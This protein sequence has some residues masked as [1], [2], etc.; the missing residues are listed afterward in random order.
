MR[1]VPQLSGV[2]ITHSPTRF[3]QDTHS[4]LCRLGFRHCSRGFECV[5]WRPKIGQMLEG[6]ICLSSPPPT[7]P[8]CS[9]ACST[10]RSLHRICP[11]RTGS[12]FSTMQK[13]GPTITASDTGRANQTVPALEAKTAPSLS[14][15][16]ASQ[17][18]TTCSPST[19]PSSQ[20][21]SKAPHPR[22]TVPTSKRA[23]FQTSSAWQRHPPVQPPRPPNPPLPPR[24]DACVGKT[25]TTPTQT[26]TN[27]TSPPSK[28]HKASRQNPLHRLVR[29]TSLGKAQAQ[30][31]LHKVAPRRARK[32]AQKGSLTTMYSIARTHAI[33][34]DPPSRSL[35]PQSHPSAQPRTAR[36][37]FTS[38]IRL[39]RTHATIGN[40]ARRH[41]RG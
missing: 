29:Q 3:L 13:L 35:P 17:W 33:I 9:M 26:R 23:C 40:A 20:T 16:S 37:G 14:P 7:Y 31:L 25:R 36:N 1:H 24:Q 30:V 5:V 38:W 32:E 6:T 19:A 12:L 39:D 18:Q 10:P 22:S 8:S 11:R 2:L 4:L 41:H 28:P 27:P 21:P 15:S 34:T